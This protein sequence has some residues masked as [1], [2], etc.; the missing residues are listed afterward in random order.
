M[1][2]LVLDWT[3]FLG[4]VGDDLELADE[5]VAAFLERAAG[6]L[7]AV[8]AAVAA[9]DPRQLQH[10]AHSFKG[11][12]AVFGAATAVDAAQRLEDL[13]AGGSAAG[14]AA[15]LAQLQTLTATLIRELEARR[16]LA[17]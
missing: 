9:A 7:A 16:R 14:A 6:L 13:G 5:I 10:A 11:S 12:L 4:R 8:G 3:E 17:A 2:D 1:S 15:D